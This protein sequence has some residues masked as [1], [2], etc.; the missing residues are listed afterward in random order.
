[1][2]RK[3]DGLAIDLVYPGG[4]LVRAA[5]RGDGRVGEDVTANVKTVRVIPHRLSGDDVPKTLEVRGEVFFAVADFTALNESLVLGGKSAVCQSS[6]RSSRFAATEG[7][8]DH[9]LP[10]SRLHLPR[11]W[12]ARRLHCRSALLTRTRLWIAGAC[13]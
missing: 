5:T 13:Q 11:H 8:E 1:M 9:R 10:Q 2:S 4:R 12:G 3:V 6:Q 7:P